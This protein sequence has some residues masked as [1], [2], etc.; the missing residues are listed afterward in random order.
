MTLPTAPSPMAFYAH[1]S[2]IDGRPL[3]D[4]IEPYRAELFEKALYT[5]DDDGRPTYNMVVA[6]RAK[7]NWKSADLVLAAFYRFFAWQSA[8]GNDAF[9]LARI[10]TQQ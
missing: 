3:L 6:G 5:F 7:K 2:W 10:A 8:S 1:L 9:I 4:V